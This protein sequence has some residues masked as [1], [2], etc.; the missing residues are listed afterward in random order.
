AGR[1]AQPAIPG[2]RGGRLHRI[3]QR[4]AV[5]DPQ[6]EREDHLRLRLVVHDVTSRP[7]PLAFV[8]GALDRADQL[9]DDHEA[10][11]A[12]WPRAGV[13]ALD[14]D[15]RALADH[16]RA[17]RI[18]DGAALGGGPGT[19]TFLGLRDGQAWFFAEADTLAIDAPHRIDLR[20]AA[21]HW[22]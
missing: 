3:A 1:P 4:R 14:A 21:A 20:S 7:S 12:L 17:L 6:P 9:R 11:A 19:A 18:V 8:H 22:P 5:R 10:L 15:G 16:E 2:R 13:I